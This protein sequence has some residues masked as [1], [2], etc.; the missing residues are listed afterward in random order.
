MVD[1]RSDRRGMSSIVV[2]TPGPVERGPQVER[3]RS[4]PDPLADVTLGRSGRAS[5]S[6]AGPGILHYSPAENRKHE[7]RSNRQLKPGSGSDLEPSLSA[8]GGYP[9][10]FGRS[11]RLND[12]SSGPRVFITP[13]TCRGSETPDLVET[14]WRERL[15]RSLFSNWAL[16]DGPDG[17]L[18]RYPARGLLRTAVP[19]V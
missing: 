13:S 2:S 7:I 3:A 16:T 8:N 4:D 17:C 1:L 19:E 6:P 11:G 9:G 12:N 18:S 14:S 10:R 5:I 15:A